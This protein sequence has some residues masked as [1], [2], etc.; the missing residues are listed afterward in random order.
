MILLLTIAMLVFNYHYLRNGDPFITKSNFI[1]RLL[2][3]LG[4]SAAV[5]LL[6]LSNFTLE[7]WLASI[8][9]FFTSFAAIHVP[10][11]N[12]QNMGRWG[13]PQNKWPSFFFGNY[14]QEQWAAMTRQKKEFSDALKMGMVGLVRGVIVFVPLLFAYPVL[15]VAAAI[16]ITAVWQPLSYFVG[17]RTPWAVFKNQPYSAE[18]GEFYI[19]IGWA[20]AFWAATGLYIWL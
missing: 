8:M 5:L 10:H 18:W 20:L 13:V 7:T 12:V 14:T 3:A 1:T 4:C 2:W 9:V 15:N 11:A 6:E 19:G 17:W 16:L